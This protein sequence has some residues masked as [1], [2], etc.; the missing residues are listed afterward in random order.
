VLGDF[1]TG[2]STQHD[3]AKQMTALHQRFKYDLVVLVGDNL[4]GSNVRRTSRRSSR[5]RSR[6]STRA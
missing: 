1:G 4:Y 6:C 2:E 3:L 5:N